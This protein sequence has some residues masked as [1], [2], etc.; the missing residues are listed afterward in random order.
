MGKKSS[1]ELSKYLFLRT[2]EAKRMRSQLFDE[3]QGDDT[4]QKRTIIDFWK[5]AFV[6]VPTHPLF[7][8][9]SATAQRT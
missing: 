6:R 7:S 9:Y 8:E 1:V 5:M 3:K 4:K 2:R